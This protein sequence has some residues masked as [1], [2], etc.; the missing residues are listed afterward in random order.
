LP[1]VADGS[2]AGLAADGLSGAAAGGLTAGGASG[3]GGLMA[4][5]VWLP[6]VADGSGAG[7]LTSVTWFLC[8]FHQW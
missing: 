4:C 1:D 8:V 3:K 5:E 2:G 6:D 7:L